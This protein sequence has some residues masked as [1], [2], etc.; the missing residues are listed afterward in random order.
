[1]KKVRPFEYYTIIAKIKE[2]G[3]WRHIKWR[4]IKG[5]S[6]LNGTTKKALE[7]KFDRLAYINVFGRDDREQRQF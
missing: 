3:S 4:N 2:A 7:A 6:L 5:A 1:M